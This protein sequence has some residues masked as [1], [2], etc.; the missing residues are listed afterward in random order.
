MIY[1]VI[2]TADVYHLK[3]SPKFQGLLVYHELDGENT[4]QE[5]TAVF[6]SVKYT[7]FVGAHRR[8]PFPCISSRYKSL[9]VKIQAYC[10]VA[11]HES[12]Q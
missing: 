12:T 3:E 11:E 7:F 8:A 1:S 4:I 2:Q 5:F 9:Q 6:E 10:R